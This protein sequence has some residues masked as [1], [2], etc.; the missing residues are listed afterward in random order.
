MLRADEPSPGLPVPDGIRVQLLGPVK[1]LL[2]ARPVPIGGPGVR[3][4]LALLS[5]NANRVVSQD[6]IVDALWAHDPPATARTIVHGHVSTLRRALASAQPGV[7]GPGLV[8]VETQSPGYRLVIEDERIDV[9]AARHLLER[10]D[11]ATPARRAELLSSALSL[12][13]GPVL[14]DIGDTVRAPELV[15]LRQAIQG[16]RIDAELEL[17]RHAEV[18]S[19]LSVLVREHPLSE[20]F[21]GQLMR[22]LYHSGRRAEALDAYH[23][24]SRRL[25]KRLGIDPGPELRDLHDRILHDDLDP[26]GRRGTGG[27]SI[28]APL[29]PMQ[30]PPAVPRL[31]GRDAELSWL[32][33]LLDEVEPTASVT[34][35]VTG[36][37]GV[38][39]STLVVSWAHQVVRRFP[40]GVL[41]AALR[42]FDPAHPPREPAEVLSALLLGLGTPAEDLPDTLEERAALYRSTLADRRMLVLLDDARTAG[43][44]QPLLPPSGG[45]IALVTSRFRLEGLLVSNAARLLALDTL[46]DAAAAGLISELAADRS[47]ELAGSANR[48]ARL[49]GNLPLALRIVGAQLAGRPASAVSQ[50]VEALEDERTRLG[51]LQ[52]PTAAE[53]GAHIG[54]RAAL[55]VSFAG[56]S[57][58]DARVFQLLG[59]YPG[60]SIGPH[61]VA[62]VCG[63]ELSEARGRLRTLAAHNLLAETGTDVF[64]AHDLVR[65]YMGERAA[66]LD[67]AERAAVLTDA[68][69]YY[70]AAADTARRTLLRVVDQL[71]CRALVPPAVLPS[72][73]DYG[74]ALNWFAAEWSNIRMLLDAALEDERHTE[75]WQLARIAHTYRV[76]RPLWD[77]WIS[78]LDL[79]LG[80]ALHTGDVRAKFWLLLSRCAVRL[81]FER[82]EGLLADAESVVTIAREIGDDRVIVPARI[83]LGCALS[84]AGRHEEAIELQREATAAARRLGDEA[85]LAQALH[86]YAEAKKRAGEYAEAIE[87]QR[88]TIE[89]DRALDNDGYLVRGLNNLAEMHLG[90]LELDEAERAARRS[91]ELCLQRGFTLQEGAARL[92]L[93]R[94]LRARGD[95]NAATAELDAAL[96]LHRRAGDPKVE[97]LR[98]EIQRSRK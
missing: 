21:A 94:V 4:L 54:V 78:L 15:D 53:D 83:H 79:G 72:L 38:G 66:E 75:V 13:V 18:I 68:L 40:D 14:A 55:D 48:L 76:S 77:D 70:L 62:A 39:K 36:T 33:L 46:P 16:A 37:A 7:G 67:P 71:D 45:S 98:A 63:C 31:A 73:A 32:D 2:D 80:A 92:V 30:L 64:V 19:A 65:V 9:H 90:A 74:G 51:A 93:G 95:L 23:G 22:A 11:G 24:F 20:R 85:M 97:E 5:L 56:L 49:C 91:I 12:W 61:L 96:E 41:F 50:V 26:A 10:A 52:L 27:L 42:G 69:R 86:N 57:D 35:L 6:E 47:G 25:V 17:G 81:V 60:R 3:G 34:G 43:Q 44:V 82:P 29:V 1:L 58:Q 8:R 87:Y 59:A 89:V 88:R 28:R 84:L